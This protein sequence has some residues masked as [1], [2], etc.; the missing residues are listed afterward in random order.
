MAENISGRAR[1]RAREKD[2]DFNIKYRSHTDCK[3]LL[4]Y[5]NAMQC[6]CTMYILPMCTHHRFNCTLNLW[7][8]HFVGKI[9]VRHSTRIRRQRKRKGEMDREWWREKGVQNRMTTKTFPRQSDIYV[10]TRLRPNVHL[11]NEHTHTTSSGAHLA[12]WNYCHW[13]FL[14]SF[15]L[16]SLFLASPSFLSVVS[17]SSFFSRW[18]SLFPSLFSRFSLHKIDKVEMKFVQQTHKFN[19]VQNSICV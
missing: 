4:W 1:E 14:I 2:I 6:M 12:A 17:N 13:I 10:C 19:A 18:L 8:C 9:T 11:H 15:H 16:N 3:P 5:R 7:N